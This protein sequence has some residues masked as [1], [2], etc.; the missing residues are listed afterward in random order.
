MPA[1]KLKNLLNP[2]GNGDLADMVQHAQAM[3]DLTGCLLRA[4][5]DEL[6]PGLRAANVRD[7]GELVV[8]ADSPAWAARLRFSADSLLAAAQAAG[9]DVR[10]ISVRVSHDV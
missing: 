9:A 3:A 8:I 10:S 7:D 4:L 1:D 6:R 2:S 5:P